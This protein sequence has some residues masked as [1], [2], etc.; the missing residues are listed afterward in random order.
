[1]ANAWDDETE[2]SERVEKVGS[3]P[4]EKIEKALDPLKITITSMVVK[5]DGDRD[6]TFAMREDL[7]TVENQIKAYIQDY[8][9][10]MNNKVKRLKDELKP[11]KDKVNELV[12]VIKDANRIYD[13]AKLQAEEAERKKRQKALDEEKAE[14]SKKVAE[15]VSKG[16]K[17]PVELAEVQQKTV[18]PTPSAKKKG[19][20][21]TET[22]SL[23]WVWFIL[24]HD[25]T[26]WDKKSRLEY[27]DIKGYSGQQLPLWQANEKAINAKFN[28]EKHNGDLPHWIHV[29]ERAK[30]T[31][32]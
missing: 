16:E 20:K 32:R 11:F 2:S 5:T 14:A 25:G 13:T 3:N 10:P 15:A 28:P 19:E 9:D 7:K 26:E 21:N 31:F 18:E 24:L 23:K 17:I 22:L 27:T 12:T 1:M 6:K 29:E 4:L 8:I 30:S